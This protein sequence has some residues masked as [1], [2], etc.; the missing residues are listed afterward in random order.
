MELE[1]IGIGAYKPL[2]GF[3][4]KEDFYSVV[5]KMRLSSGEL[6]PLPVI[7]PILNDEAKNIKSSFKNSFIF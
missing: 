7:L 3:M 5:N 4:T 2:K 1:K 6:F